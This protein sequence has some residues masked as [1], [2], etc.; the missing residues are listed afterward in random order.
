MRIGIVTFYQAANHGA[1]LQQYA[2]KETLRRRYAA[3]VHILKYPSRFL[4]K[5]IDSRIHSKP[6][7]LRLSRLSDLV[8]FHLKTRGCFQYSPHRMDEPFDSV[9]FG[10]DEIWNIK[11]YFS[12]YCPIL[13][14]AGI[15]TRSKVAYAPSF[16]EMSD[17]KEIPAEVAGLLKEFD[18][19]S[20]RDHNSQERVLDITGKSVPIVLDPTFLYSFE[21]E[22]S[23]HKASTNDYLLVYATHVSAEQKDKIKTYAKKNGLRIVSA[24][25]YQSWVDKHQNHVHPFKTL[26]LFKS[27]HCVFTNTFHGLA[28]GLK[29]QKPIV[30]GDISGKENKVNSLCSRLRIQPRFLDEQEA[31]DETWINGTHQENRLSQLQEESLD[32]L[33]QALKA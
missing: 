29:F 12:G 11:N 13:F 8:T 9:V 6:R 7:W 10:S 22:M 27:A 33:D 23:R 26:S 32:F 15:R 30:L 5:E 4:K 28:L 31:L 2:L 24:G 14:G 3:D 20:I 16:G 17:G 25:N 18:A 19:I 21:E 1:F